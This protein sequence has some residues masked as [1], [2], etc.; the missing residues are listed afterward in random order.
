MAFVLF[1]EKLW[2]EQVPRAFQCTATVL[3]MLE[4]LWFCKQCCRALH[5]SLCFAPAAPADPAFTW[6]LRITVSSDKAVAHRNGASAAREA[7][8]T[9]HLT[10]A[11]PLCF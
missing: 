7:R 1:P 11:P 8:A 3:F 10:S 4:C 9:G 2:T 6:L 5:C